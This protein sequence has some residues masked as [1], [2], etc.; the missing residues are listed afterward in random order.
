MSRFIAGSMSVIIQNL[1]D[2][3]SYLL[4]RYKLNDGLVLQI[5]L[6]RNHFSY[7][8]SDKNGIDTLVAILLIVLQLNEISVDLACEINR[9]A[10]LFC[11]KDRI[12]EFKFTVYE[13][14]DRLLTRCYYIDL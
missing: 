9:L 6:I 11:P 1:N 10:K 14:Y 8:F 5:D 13:I 7:L 3:K 4:R 12:N 2:Q